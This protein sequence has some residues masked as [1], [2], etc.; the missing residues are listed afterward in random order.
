MTTKMTKQPIHNNALLRSESHKNKKKRRNNSITHRFS[1]L[2][3][4][5]TVTLM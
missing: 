4:E 3:G 2:A 5:L 1:D